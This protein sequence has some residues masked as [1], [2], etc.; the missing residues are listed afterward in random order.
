MEEATRGGGERREPRALQA[1]GVPGRVSAG[2]GGQAR[3]WGA[4]QM[5]ASENGGACQEIGAALGAG[6][7]RCVRGEGC[8]GR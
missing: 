8:Y 4:P 6:T 5:E 1:A 2:Q 3:C 7:L